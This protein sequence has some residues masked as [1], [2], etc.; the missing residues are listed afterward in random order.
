MAPM[1][2]TQSLFP[3][4]R[5]YKHAGLCDSRHLVTKPVLGSVVH[6]WN[7]TCQATSPA[8]LEQLPVTTSIATDATVPEGHKGLH[9]F[10]Y[11]TGGAEEHDG[12]DVLVSSARYVSG[13]MSF[14]LPVPDYHDYHVHAVLLHMHNIIHFWDFMVVQTL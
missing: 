11:G 8:R 9:G 13:R 2:F 12:D 10:L 6:K 1:P 3:P 4:T 5:S 7:V 14:C